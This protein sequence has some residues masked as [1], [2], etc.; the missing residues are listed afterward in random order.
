ML[1]KGAGGGAVGFFFFCEHAR[2]GREFGLLT[3]A[4]GAMWTIRVTRGGRVSVHRYA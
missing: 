4:N 3:E 2:F 1:N